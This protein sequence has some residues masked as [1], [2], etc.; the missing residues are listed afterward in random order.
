ML[1]VHRP[2]GSLRGDVYRNRQTCP[3]EPQITWPDCDVSRILD[4]CQVCAR[5][6]AGGTSRWSWL[7]CHTCR[8]VESAL[9][10]WLG[11]RVLPLGRHSILNGVARS[12]SDQ[13]PVA[14]E[15]FAASFN[16][17][18]A[19]WE[20]LAAWGS[21]ETHRLLAAVPAECGED[22]PLRVW[23]QCFP[24]SIASS[25]DAYER[26]LGMGLPPALVAQAA[27]RGGR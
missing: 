9:Q 6:T 1:S 17:L 25:A 8:A 2:C 7:A 20:R 27:E 4:L 3:C 24:A 26:L 12:V 19:S 22:V 16:S 15:Q 23:R 18:G 13:R 5:G 11:V 14:S 10:S 21:E